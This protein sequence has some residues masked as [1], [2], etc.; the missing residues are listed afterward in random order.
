MSVAIILGSIIIGGFI[1]VGLLFISDRLEELSKS[2][3]EY[4]GKR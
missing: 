1:F 3:K 2:S 4:R